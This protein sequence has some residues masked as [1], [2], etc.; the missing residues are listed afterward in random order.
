MKS[1]S[2]ILAALV[3]AMA[4]TAC[5]G[6]S[7]T[8][9]TP[10]VVQP[11]FSTTDTVVGTGDEA[12]AGDLAV[13]QYTGYLYSATATDHHG[14]LFDST[15]ARNATTTF[16][17]GAGLSIPAGLD[18]GTAGMKVG[19]HRTVILP[20]NLGF[21]TVD[22]TA[23]LQPGAT[24]GVDIPANSPLIYEVELVSVKK[25]PPVTTV[26]P[27]TTLVITDTFLGSGTAVASGSKLLVHYTGW[28][29]DGTKSDLKGAQFDT[30]V[31]SGVTTGFAFTVGAGSVIAGWDQGVIGMAAGGKRTLIIPPSLAYG[32]AGNAT[33]P[34]NATLVFDIQVISV[35]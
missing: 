26:P 33:I 20:S 11:A 2:Q 35:N 12:D 5:G 9:A 15:Y 10:A 22:T 16:T 24:T 23:P 3:C 30:D 29:Y 21:G 1:M 17:I 13:I 28:L 6:G 31:A 27:P 7:K 14:T 18:Q 19:G 32:A 8:P 34:P 4:V 25:A